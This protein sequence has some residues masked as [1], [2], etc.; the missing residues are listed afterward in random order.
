MVVARAIIEN[1]KKNILKLYLADINRWFHEAVYQINVLHQI[2]VIF[3]NYR[4]YT[5]ALVT[6]MNTDVHGHRT[7]IFKKS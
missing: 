7:G 1:S 2:R 5:K 6:L 4:N 3:N